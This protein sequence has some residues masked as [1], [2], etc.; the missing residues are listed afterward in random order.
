VPGHGAVVDREFVQD[1]RADIG[2]VAETI[3]DLA[4][5]GVPLDG[6]IDTVEWPFPKEGLADAVRRGYEHLPL[7]G[8]QLPLL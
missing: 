3:R 4:L 1:Q 8:R 2:I 5:R 6:A 7:I